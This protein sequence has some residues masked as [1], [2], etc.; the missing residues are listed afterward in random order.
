MLSHSD[1]SSTTFTPL[2]PAPQNTH[3][4]LTRAKTALLGPSAFTVAPVLP[5][6]K[7][8]KE[9]LHLPQWLAAMHEELAALTTNNT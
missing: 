5:L 8:T 2:N 7:S 6:P 1:L 9:A 4:M 3:P